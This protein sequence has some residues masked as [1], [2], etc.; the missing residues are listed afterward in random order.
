VKS[1]WRALGVVAFGTSFTACIKIAPFTEKDA[2]GD[3][4]DAPSDGDV[5]A[6]G[7][8]A[9]PMGTGVDVTNGSLYRVAFSTEAFHYPMSM[10]VGTTSIIGGGN[11]VGCADEYGV[12]IG[13]YPAGRIIG[14]MESSVMQDDITIEFSGPPVAKVSIDWGTQ[15][16][17]GGSPGTVTGRSTFTF[18]PDGRIN[19]GDQVTP[20]GSLDSNACTC[21]GA[22]SW[23]VTSFFTANHANV[24][25]VFGA[26]LPS[27][28]STSNPANPTVCFNG[29][30]DSYQFAMG[31]RTG[32]T[33]RVRTPIAGAQG[34][35]AFV[36]DLING[37]ASTTFSTVAEGQTTWWVST[38]SNCTDLRNNVMPYADNSGQSLP[39]LITQA[40]S[41]SPVSFGVALDGIFGGENGQGAMGYQPA[42]PDIHLTTNADLGAFA[43]WLALQ[44]GD[45]IASV[46]KTGNPP[47]PWYFQQTRSNSNHRLFWFPDGLKV[48]EEIVITIQ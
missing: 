44:S 15:Y 27:D 6:S 14:H 12:G 28:N 8:I 34:T 13:L 23:Y 31:W 2:G 22:D 20:T 18:F 11:G 33:P 3:A 7:A 21:S 17:C 36:Y 29:F 19:R 38:S 35:I 26:T 43:F 47:D 39:T 1:C 4:T 30:N 42:H 25:N 5:P 48:G 24:N 46:T 16:P 9:V 40:G 41:D 32:R 45:D 37:G 10:T